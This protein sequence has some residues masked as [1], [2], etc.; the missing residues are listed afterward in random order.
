MSTEKNEQQPAE[1][2]YVVVKEWGDAQIQEHAAKAGSERLLKEVIIT[3][4]DGYKYHYLVKRPNRNVVNAI[5][6]KKQGDTTD[7]EGITKLMLGLVLEG[8][9]AMLEADA[10]I[11]GE[12]LKEIGGLM[13]AATGEIKKI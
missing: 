12:L 4:D 7:T 5:A 13:K 2:Q 9:R 6:S 10:A 8:D 11:S 3:T 1:V